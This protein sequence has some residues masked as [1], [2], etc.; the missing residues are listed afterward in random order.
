M[1]PFFFQFG[2]FVVVGVI[3]TMIDFGVLNLLIWLTAISAGIYFS[4]FKALGFIFANI[5]SYFLNKFWTFGQHSQVGSGEYGKFF[6]ISLIGLLINV[7]VASLVVNLIGPRF[8]IGP[9]LWANVGAAFG[10]GA[11]LL[12]NFIGYKFIVFKS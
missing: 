7:G 8:E 9:T 10:S 4:L 3:N 6:T 2:K 1:N 12:W 11:G 5:N